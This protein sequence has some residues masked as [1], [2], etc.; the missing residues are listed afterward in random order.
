MWIL[1]EFSSENRKGVGLTVPNNSYPLAF[2]LA[3]AFRLAYSSVVS[4]LPRSFLSVGWRRPSGLS[5]RDYGPRNL[6]K[7]APWAAHTW[8][9]V[10]CVL[11]GEPQSR[12]AP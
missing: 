7:T 2:S 3:I 8:R 11:P 5:F 12:R 1:R 6:M 9:I 4:R 10:P